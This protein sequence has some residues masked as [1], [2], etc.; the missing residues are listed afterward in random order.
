VTGS[1]IR[2]EETVLALHLHATEAV[3]RGQ[4]QRLLWRTRRSHSLC[5]LAAQ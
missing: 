1:T 2:A 3:G 5:P 4:I